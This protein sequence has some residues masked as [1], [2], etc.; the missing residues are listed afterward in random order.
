VVDGARLITRVRLPSEEAPIAAIAS[1]CVH[2]LTRLW[3]CAE[4]APRT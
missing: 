1:I 3:S 4:F 2:L